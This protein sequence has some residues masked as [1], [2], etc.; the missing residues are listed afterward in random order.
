MSDLAVQKRRPFLMPIGLMVVTIMLGA[1]V[2]LG[3]GWWLVT[4]KSTVVIVIR[5][6]EKVEGGEDPP[7]TEAGEARAARLARMFGDAGDP[8]RL[9]AIYV[10]APQRN[11]MTAAP[12]AQRLGLTPTIVDSADPQALA[13]RVLR[14]HAGQRVLIVGHADT[15]PALIAALSGGAGIAAIDPTDYG[16]MIIVAVPRVGRANVLALRY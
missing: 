16:S 12:L 11:R 14:E 9:E 2:L 1:A 3:A 5:H 10:T 4:A 6:A 7:L 15:M 8:L 13:R